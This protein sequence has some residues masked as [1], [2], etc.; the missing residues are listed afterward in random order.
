MITIFEGPDGSGKTTTAKAYAR[1]VAETGQPV[2]FMHWG[3]VKKPFEEYLDFLARWYITFAKKPELRPHLIMDRFYFSELMYGPILRK[4]NRLG[5]TERMLQRVLLG[6]ETLLV[7]CD[8][9][10]DVIHD[11]W[12]ARI[13]DELVKDDT[14]VWAITSAYRETLQDRWPLPVVEFDYTQMHIAALFS[15]GAEAHRSPRNGGPGMGMFKPGVQLIVG[16]A[17]GGKHYNAEGDFPFVGASGCSAWLAE[18]MR[19]ATSEGE[20]Y[21]VNVF[22]RDGAATNMDFIEELNPSAVIT[23]GSAASEAMDRTPFPSELRYA[24]HHPQY[25]R[26]FKLGEAYPFISFLTRP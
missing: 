14:H 19:Y 3:E 11:N 24:F 2:T 15:I 20:L 22:D 21:W 13:D 1:R 6:N 4:E 10:I 26:R 7:R 12:A 8:P 18:E 23:L 5:S 25:H 9:G 17:P 16:D